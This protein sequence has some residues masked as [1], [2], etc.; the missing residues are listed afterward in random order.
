MSQLSQNKPESLFDSPIVLHG[1]MIAPGKRHRNCECIFWH[2]VS[3]KVV[4]ENYLVLK[5]ITFKYTPCYYIDV[6]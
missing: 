4:K 3:Q 2:F 5:H 1:H 6:M